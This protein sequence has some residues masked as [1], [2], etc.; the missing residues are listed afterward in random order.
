MS[1]AGDGLAEKGKRRLG[2]VQTARPAAESGRIGQPIGVFQ[3][4]HCLLPRAVLHKAPPQCL[5]A[6][7]Q[8]VMRVRERK[9]RKEGEG[10]PAI[11][12]AAATD[13]N[14]VVMFIVRLLAATAVADDR[15]A[16]TNRASPQ[17]DLVAV[18]G[19]VGFELVR[20]GGKWDKEN[21]TSQGLCPGVDPPRSEPEAEPLL[22]KRNPTGR[23]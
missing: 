8:A 22:L 4:G 12:A 9:Q 2:A 10:L 11:R 5:T 13:P 15:I 21:R 23:E 18:F 6:R 1:H 16:F 17:D 3:L 14:P 7:Q 19:P 20:R